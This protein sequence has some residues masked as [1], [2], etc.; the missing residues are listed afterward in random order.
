MNTPNLDWVSMESAFVFI[1]VHA[2]CEETVAARLR[3]IEGVD[4]A[5]VVFGEYDV[6]A[7]VHALSREGVDSLIANRVQK[8]DGLKSLH[9]SLVIDVNQPYL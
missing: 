8:I 3:E 2:G 4:E 6:V 9:V 7:R 1:R 5:F